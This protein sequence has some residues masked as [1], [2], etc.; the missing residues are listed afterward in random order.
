MRLGFAAMNAGP[1]FCLRKAD[2]NEPPLHQNFEELVLKP[3]GMS[4]LHALHLVVVVILGLG[5]VRD[6]RREKGGGRNIVSF[7]S[8]R[9]EGG[10][11]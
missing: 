7:H 8:F 5:I 1:V 2:L 4:R 6:L 3:K 10:G 11:G 9:E